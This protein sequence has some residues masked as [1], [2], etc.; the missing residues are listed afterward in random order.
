MTQLIASGGT[1]YESDVEELNARFRAELR[2]SPPKKVLVL[3]REHFGDIVNSTAS[4]SAIRKAFPKAKIVFEAGGQADSILKD[5]GIVDQIWS[6]PKRQGAIGKLRALARIAMGHFDL[7]IIL[8]DGRTLVSVAKVAGIPRRAGIY[9]YKDKHLFNAYVPYRK[10]RHET[11]DLFRE[12]LEAIGVETKGYRPFFPISEQ[13]LQ[14][15]RQKLGEGGWKPGAPIVGMQYSATRSERML[16]EKTFSDLVS[17]LGHL[18]YFV[19]LTGSPEEQEKLN[20]VASQC[21][22]LPFV[23]AGRYE[24]GEFAA[25]LSM[26]TA[27][28]T[29]DTGPMHLAAAV[30]APIVAVYGPSDPVETGPW[31]PNNRIL[32]HH[33][34]CVLRN[35]KN[36]TGSCMAQFSSDE[37]V[38]AIQEVQK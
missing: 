38:S 10:D 32:S 7:A 33:C 21:H 17:Q 3:G 9:R 19:V 1:R 2:N 16:P 28:V 22:P 20:C 12:L 14:I 36:C 29:P 25:L 4:L 24:I 26:V 6:R 35:L 5:F 23:A 8:E 34:D 30:N 11:L 13:S 27:F 15:A 18:G 37:I 31:G